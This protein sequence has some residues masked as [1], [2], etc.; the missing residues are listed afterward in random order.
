VSKQQIHFAFS[1]PIDFIISLFVTLTSAHT[2]SFEVIKRKAEKTFLRV[3]WLPRVEIK[4]PRIFFL[5]AC[6][7]PRTCYGGVSFRPDFFSL[8]YNS[9][10][11]RVNGNIKAG[12]ETR[13]DEKCFLHFATFIM[14][15]HRYCVSEQTTH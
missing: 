10:N 12:K 9:L 14:D 6:R 4:S 8:V 5:I 11:A 1:Q 3:F 15:F 7:S 13:A 2:Y